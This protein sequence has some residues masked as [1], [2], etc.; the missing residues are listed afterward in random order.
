VIHPF[1]PIDVGTFCSVSVSELEGRGYRAEGRVGGSR[2]ENMRLRLDLDG[3]DRLDLVLGVKEIKVERKLS[4]D[5][6]TCIETYLD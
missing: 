5:I 1:N 4:I 2:V 3:D 6:N